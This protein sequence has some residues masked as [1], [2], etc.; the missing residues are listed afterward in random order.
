[1]VAL[2]GMNRGCMNM[3]DNRGGG[4]RVCHHARRLDHRLLLGQQHGLLGRPLVREELGLHRVGPRT[5]R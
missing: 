4:A 1:M 2:G 5:G 3:M